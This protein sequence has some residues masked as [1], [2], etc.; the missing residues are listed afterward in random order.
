MKIFIV[1]LGLLL[2]NISIM[3]YRGDFGRYA[4]LH[5]ALDNIAFECAEIAAHDID[6][7][8]MFADDMWEYTLKSLN[9]INVKGY[10]C[11]ISVEDGLASVFIRMDVGGLFRFPL[12]SD[13]S[14]I[15]TNRID[16]SP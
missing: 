13:A 15:A 11:E 8:R 10:I 3:S 12:F 7:A 1:F 9:N 6:E 5:R 2:V 16:N 4:Y 14:I